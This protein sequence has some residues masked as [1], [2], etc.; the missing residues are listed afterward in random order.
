[1]SKKAAAPDATRQ[2]LDQLRQLDADL[3]GYPI[4]G[5]RIGLGPWAP[6]EQARTTHRR[7][8]VEVR[9]MSDPHNPGPVTG[10]T[11]EVDDS[12][13]EKLEALPDAAA[14]GLTRAE[15]ARMKALGRDAI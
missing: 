10:H 8:V 1:M 7:D 15:I 4:E 12:L 6:P 3:H 14:H 2:E 13:A 5:T 11:Y 9:D